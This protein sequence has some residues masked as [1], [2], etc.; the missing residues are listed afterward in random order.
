MK[1]DTGYY[2]YWPYRDRP[3]I[4]WP[5]GARLAFWV[6][7]RGR[8]RI[9]PCRATRSVTTAIASATRVR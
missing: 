9:P 6:E 1:E 4:T 7:R 3:R 8:I 2:D 5:N